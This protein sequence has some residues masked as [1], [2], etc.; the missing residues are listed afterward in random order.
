MK[1]LIGKKLGMT[2]FFSEE[3]GQIPVTVIEAGPCVVVSCKKEESKNYTKLLLGFQKAKYPYHWD[4]QKMES[5]EPVKGKR[6]NKPEA[7]IFSKANLHAHSVLLEFRVNA[8]DKYKTGD[9]LKVE[10]VFKEGLKVDVRSKSKGHGFSGVIKR[11]NFHGGRKSHG[12]MFH[13]APGSIGQGTTPGR[14]IKGH[15]LPGQYGN[16]NI[17]IQNLEVVKIIPEKNLLLV[18]GAVPGAKGTL[19]KV[20]ETVKLR[21]REFG[22]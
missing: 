6:L 7:G 12:S 1:G 9:V 17:T 14:V 10:D 2:H 5:E 22:K 11:H 20:Q 4:K 19:V 13:R 8:K 21:G 15:P 3:K 18:K 16:K